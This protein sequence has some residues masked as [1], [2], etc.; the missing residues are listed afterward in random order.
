LLITLTVLATNSSY[1][2]TEERVGESYS[3]ICR[4]FKHVT[5]LI[6]QELGHMLNYDKPLQFYEAQQIKFA[7][8]YGTPNIGCVMDGTL[9][10]TRKPKYKGES[11]YSGHKKAYGVCL[12]L[13]SSFEKEI[14]YVS[15]GYPGSTHDSAVF[16][17]SSLLNDIENGVVPIN[18]NNAILGDSAFPDIDCTIISS[19]NIDYSSPRTISEHVFARLKTKFQILN[20]TIRQNVDHVPTIVVCC[21]ILS[22]IDL[23]FPSNH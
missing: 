12:L 20:G 16:R 14:L 11:Y 18:E 1:R 17:A 2:T 10:R 6:V 9:I 13:V 3:A 8:R 22:N 4:V 7:T 19:A 21:C 15:A 23:E 5:T